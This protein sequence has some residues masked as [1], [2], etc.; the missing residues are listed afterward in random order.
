MN[1]AKP[2]Q[3]GRH[4]V[5][6]VARISDWAREISCAEAVL[7]EQ[8]K[9]RATRY[10]FPEDRAR[11]ILGRML[12]ARALQE[13]GGGV[14]EPLILRQTDRGRPILADE[15]EI[16]FSISHSGV[17]VAVALTL[18]GRV[19]ID[20]EAISRPAD[21]NSLSERIFSI[22]E[23]Q[24]LLTGPEGER[25]AV[26]FRGWTAKEAY[27]KALGLGLPG[28]L[29]GVA[30]PLDEADPSS[31]RVFHPNAQSGAWCLHRLPLLD[32]YSGC[33]VW[34][35]PSKSLDFRVVNPTGKSGF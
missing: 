3:L 24:T 23:Q 30:V 28:G 33:V 21:F 22:S 25:P 17:L 6:R 7:N 4:V 15:P 31:P 12:L 10:R 18:K 26:F 2:S 8:D 5:V 32:G 13:C 14:P 1:D 9:A 20:L 19:G 16:Q 11:F 27:L 34:D 35:D 29:K